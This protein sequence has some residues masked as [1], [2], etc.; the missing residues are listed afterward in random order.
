MENGMNYLIQLHGEMQGKKQSE[1]NEFAILAQVNWVAI[2]I[3][4]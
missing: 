3:T 4:V 2:G 1:K